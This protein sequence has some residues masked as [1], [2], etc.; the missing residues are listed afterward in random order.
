MSR[1]GK[2]KDKFII[3]GLRGRERT[4]IVLPSIEGQESF[5]QAELSKDQAPIILVRSND[6]GDALGFWVHQFMV[7]SNGEISSK[8]ER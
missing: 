1:V 3:E 4:A 6:F 2:Q 8:K 7:S 5:L